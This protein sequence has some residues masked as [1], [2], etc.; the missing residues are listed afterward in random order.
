MGGMFDPVH[1]G[2]L[3]I[4]LNTQQNLQLDRLA[5][6]PCGTPVHRPDDLTPATHRLAMLELAVQDHTGLVVDDRECRESVPSYAFN[7]LTAI[8]RENPEAILYYLMGQDAFNKFHTWYHWQEILEL[9]HI[10]VAARPGATSDL[11]ADLAREVQARTVNNVDEMRCSTQGKIFTLEIPLLDISSTMVRER[12][13]CHEGIDD[14]VP[15]A[16]ADYID[17]NGLYTPENTA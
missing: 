6:L 7:S 8:R 4:A 10:V 13:R 5:L 14:L 17:T 15:A 3:S 11:D 9:T 2:H 12:V 1:N 16:V